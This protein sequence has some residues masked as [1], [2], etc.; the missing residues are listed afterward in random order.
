MHFE[1]ISDL[2]KKFQ[3]K[4]VI[5]MAAKSFSNSNWSTKSW[6]VFDGK[7]V[8]GTGSGFFEYEIEIPEKIKKQNYNKAFFIIEASA[9]ELFEKDKDI[10]GYVDP[11]IDFMKG[12]KLSPSKNPNSYPMTDTKL[13]QSEIKVLVNGKLKSETILTVSY[14]HLTLPTNREV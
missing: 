3:G 6:E 11:G 14:T 9:K 13:F 10:T 12:S 2:K 8:N 7:K 5:S 1:V 4:E